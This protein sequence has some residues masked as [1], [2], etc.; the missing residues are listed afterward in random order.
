MH[1]V[2]GGTVHHAPLDNQTLETVMQE[3]LA[4]LRRQNPQEGTFEARWVCHR[5]IG[6][7]TRVGKVVGGT[8][9]RLSPKLLV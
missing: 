6:W 2:D 5:G 1:N 4:L 3:T 7:G 8:G 9:L